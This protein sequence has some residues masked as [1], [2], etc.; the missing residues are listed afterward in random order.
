VA[1]PGQSIQAAVNRANPG[2]TVLAKPGLY[3]QSAQIRAAIF[4]CAEG[5]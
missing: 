1:G 4:G 5:R 2:D 3:Y